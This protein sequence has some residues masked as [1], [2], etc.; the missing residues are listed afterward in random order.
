MRV[1]SVSQIPAL[2][3]V[4]RLRKRDITY[5]WSCFPCYSERLNGGTQITHTWPWSF[6]PSRCCE[7]I[8]G[9]TKITHACP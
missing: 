8:I 6:F 2:A 3:P 9:C 5:A 4:R 1:P 7:G